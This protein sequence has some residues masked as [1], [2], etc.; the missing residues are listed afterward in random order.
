MAG[1]VTDDKTWDKFSA[2]WNAELNG[3]PY[4]AFNAK[5]FKG[6]GATK[7]AERFYRII[8]K[9]LEKAFCVTCSVPEYRAVMARCRFPKS[10]TEAPRYALLNDPN[11]FLYRALIEVC[12]NER[13]KLDITE[14]IDLIFDQTNK[15]EALVTSIYDYLYHSAS[16]LGIDIADFGKKP[17]FEDDEKTPA[18]QAADLL[19]RIVRCNLANG[20]D[21]TKMPWKKMKPI[22]HLITEIDEKYILQVLD[23]SF[24][25]ENS[26]I[27]EEYAK[28]RHY[29][30]YDLLNRL[31]KHLPAFIRIPILRMLNKPHLLG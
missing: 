21:P 7:R 12:Y 26:E 24:S 1:Y 2:D 4:V 31:L 28:A 17:I 15:Y 30:F 18:L 11:L 29:R 20:E 19:A 22:R 13:K 5:I 10:L 6:G 8:E 27:Y 23:S 25:K 16:A 14:P 3:Q 9:H